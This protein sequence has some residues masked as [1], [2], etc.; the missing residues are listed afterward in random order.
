M[1]LSS[2]AATSASF[3]VRLG[4]EWLLTPLLQYQN[5]HLLLHLHPSTPFYNNGRLWRLLEGDLRQ[6]ELA[7]QHGFA[8][9]PTIHPGSRHA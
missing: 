9:R 2:R 3:T 7:I 6:H 4:W 1:T 8:I 5:Y